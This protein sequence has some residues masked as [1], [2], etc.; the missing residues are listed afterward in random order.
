MYVQLMNIICVE[1]EETNLIRIF[2]GLFFYLA[3]F[4]SGYS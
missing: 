3:H 2:Q 1:R 4:C